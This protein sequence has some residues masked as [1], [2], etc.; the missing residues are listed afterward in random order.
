MAVGV[1]VIAAV[2]GG[3]TVGLGGDQVQNWWR[4]LAA[5]A[6]VAFVAHILQQ[7]LKIMKVTKHDLHWIAE[8]CSYIEKRM[9]AAAAKVETFAGICSRFSWSSMQTR[10]Q[11]R[12]RR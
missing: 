4:P 11:A 10:M 7:M 5:V 9:D 3:A 6:V 1:A 8:K 2:V 12:L